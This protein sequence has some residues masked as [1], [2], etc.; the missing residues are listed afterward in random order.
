VGFVLTLLADYSLR[1]ERSL[2]ATGAITTFALC[3][4]SSAPCFSIMKMLAGK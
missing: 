2:E 3:L 4:T 1:R